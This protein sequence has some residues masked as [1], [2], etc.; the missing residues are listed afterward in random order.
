MIYGGGACRVSKVQRLTVPPCATE[1]RKMGCAVS[2]RGPRNRAE[3]AGNAPRR[4]VAVRSPLRAEEPAGGP[5]IPVRSRWAPSVLPSLRREARQNGHH[6]DL[7]VQAGQRPGPAASAGL[8]EK[9]TRGDAYAAHGCLR[10]ASLGSMPTLARLASQRR[11]AVSAHAPQRKND[12]L[13]G[14]ICCISRKNACWLA[15]CCR[16]EHESKHLLRNRR[17]RGGCS[18]A[19]LRPLAH[20]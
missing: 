15:P 13:A 7:D 14:Q 10:L 11:G 4:S 2:S 18:R 17:R 20:A 8:A 9:V 3:T 16:L 5:R 19:S 1:I 6:P 12:T